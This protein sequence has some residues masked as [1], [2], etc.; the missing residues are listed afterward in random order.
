MMQPAFMPWQ[1]LF[2]LIL[3]S[4]VFIY[5]DDFQFVVQSHHTRNKLFVNTQ[6]VDFYTVPVQK[7][8]SFEK[9]LN[10]T[11]IISNTLWK[12]KLLKRIKNVYAKSQFYKEIY[13]VIESWLSKDY[14]S[15]ADLN[16][17]GIET[18]CNLL[19][20]NTPRLYSS[21]FSQQT[22]S[23]TTRTKRVEELLEWANATLYLSAFG[24]F[25]YMKADGYD[26]RKFPVLFQNYHPK[27][28][29]QIQSLE[30]VPYLSIVDALLNVGSKATR[31]LIEH[32][33][34]KWLSFEER[35]AM[36]A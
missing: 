10:Q 20:I 30:F 4:D 31:V 16:I 7:S 25:D 19:S 3:H 22:Q 5:L 17:A 12:H 24:S 27:P 26:A 1:G 32:G 8:V 34:E 11:Q 36:H 33:T 29:K 9:P 6:Q 13:P 14:L 35:E 23:R 15:L 21:D 2:E 28:Y 18:I